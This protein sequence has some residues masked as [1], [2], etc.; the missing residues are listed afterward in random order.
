MKLRR[1]EKDQY[2]KMFLGHRLSW[3]ISLF[4]NF[5][6][7]PFFPKTV[8]RLLLMPSVARKFK[9]ICRKL[10]LFELFNLQ[11]CKLSLFEI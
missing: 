5:F 11:T 7:P 6:C 4:I 9:L 3:T 2:L 10:A 8:T 1:I